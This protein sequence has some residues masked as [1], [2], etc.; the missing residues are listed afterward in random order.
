MLSSTPSPALPVALAPSLPPAVD[1]VLARVAGCRQVCAERAARSL[2]QVLQ[3][4]MCS[5]WPEMALAFSRLT[6]TGMPVEFA[7]TSRDTSLRWT[8]EVAPPEAPDVSR[9]DAAFAEAGMCSAAAPW[10]ALQRVGVDRGAPL[11]YGAWLGVRHFREADA[12][13]VYVELPAGLLPGIWRRRHPLLAGTYL[14]WRMAGVGAGG[15]T[16]F[17]AQVDDMEPALLHALEMSAFGQTGWWLDAITRLLG[18]SDLPRPSGLSLA[19]DSAG[20]LHALTWF[21]SAKALFRDDDATQAA[22]LRQVSDGS[23]AEVLRALGGG[24][25]DGRWRHGM[26]GVGV[27]GSETAWV[28]VGIRP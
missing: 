9:V 23:S 14:Q 17:Y 16:E 27:D 10:A 7:W 21:A 25:R 20:K 8:A 12:F 22:L 28:Q 2:A 1:A 13:K 19:F 6:N 15:S 5:D 24:A 11:R 4:V 3:R 26:V 18:R